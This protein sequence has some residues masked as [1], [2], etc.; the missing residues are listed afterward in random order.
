M[1]TNAGVRSGPL[2]QDRGIGYPATIG[3]NVGTVSIGVP[4]SA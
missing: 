1:L 2:L 4:P 3:S